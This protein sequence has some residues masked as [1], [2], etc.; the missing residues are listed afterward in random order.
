MLRTDELR[1]KYNSNH[2]QEIKV[3]KQEVMAME[4]MPNCSNLKGFYNEGDEVSQIMINILQ[5]H[6]NLYFDFDP[7]NFKIQKTIP[8]KTGRDKASFY[9][10]QIPFDLLIKKRMM[11]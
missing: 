5:H 1:R 11:K 7:E 4:N 6:P 3:R 10:C 2:R 8:S 9:L